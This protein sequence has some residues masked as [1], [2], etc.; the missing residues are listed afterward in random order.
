VK[1]FMVE[2]AVRQ[3]VFCVLVSVGLV[4]SAAPPEVAQQARALQAVLR[5]ADEAYYNK[6]QPVMSDPAYDSLRKQYNQQA[7]F[8]CNEPNR[9][10]RGPYS[11][12]CIPSG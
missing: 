7:G 12:L 9:S 4:C 2:V 10:R 1:I 5:Q 6:H 3:K 8:F 11:R